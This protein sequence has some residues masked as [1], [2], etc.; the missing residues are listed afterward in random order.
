MA[1]R[2]NESTRARRIR[3]GIVEKPKVDTTNSK[4]GGSGG[5]S[6]K[7]TKRTDRFAG[8]TTK[9][10]RDFR[11]KKREP[12]QGQDPK[13]GELNP[14]DTQISKPAF[15]YEAEFRNLQI[16]YQDQLRQQQQAMEAERQ[17]RELYER[18]MLA[19]QA[20]SGQ[21]AEY[22]LGSPTKRTRGGTFGFG[23]R[24]RKLLPAMRAM[25]GGISGATGGSLNT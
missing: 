8:M 18:T 12:D 7:G 5:G 21:S 17:Q 16:D 23:R 14:A 4:K 10:I 24:R 6:K 9:E 11:A 13:P 19:N 15:D 3:R 20:R 25:L 1:K 2:K 22:Q